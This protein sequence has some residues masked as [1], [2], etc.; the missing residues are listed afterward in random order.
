MDATNLK[1]RSFQA[2]IDKFVEKLDNIDLYRLCN[3]LTERFIDHEPDEIQMSFIEEF[4]GKASWFMFVQDEKKMRDGNESVFK[5]R[6]PFDF[7]KIREYLLYKTQSRFLNVMSELSKMK[8]AESNFRID[9]LNALKQ[10]NN[11]EFDKVDGFSD[12]FDVL[13]KYKIVNKNLL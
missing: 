6:P 9:I 11:G 13:I 7:R 5:L 4:F 8:L 12:I 2:N 3:Y 1:E 10:E